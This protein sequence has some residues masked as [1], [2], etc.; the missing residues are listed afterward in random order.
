MTVDERASKSLQQRRKGNRGAGEEMTTKSD[1]QCGGMRNGE[2]HVFDA[3]SSD[4]HELLFSA[5]QLE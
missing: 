4:V 1:G 5:M 3:F 2:T